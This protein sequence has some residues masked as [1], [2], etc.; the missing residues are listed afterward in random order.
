L[1]FLNAPCRELF[2]RGGFQWHLIDSLRGCYVGHDPSGFAFSGAFDV[3][4]DLIVFMLLLCNG[5]AAASVYILRRTPPMQCTAVPGVGL[6]DAAD[7]LSCSHGL[8][9]D[10][11]AARNTGASARRRRYPKSP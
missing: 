5:L 9:D 7:A 1:D 8:P 11:H 2:V 3:L 6:P 4:T 10:Q